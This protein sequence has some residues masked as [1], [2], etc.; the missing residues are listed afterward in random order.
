MEEVGRE[1]VM[2]GRVREGDV[3][4][5]GREGGRGGSA[6]VREKWEFDL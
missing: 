2:D 5:R 6:F 1:G 4:G 3:S